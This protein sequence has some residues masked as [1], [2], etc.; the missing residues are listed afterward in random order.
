[1]VLHKDI[2]SATANRDLKDA[3]IDGIVK[4]IGI[5]NQT[6]YQFAR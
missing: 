2:S 5:G 6:K 1:M 4:S 3:F